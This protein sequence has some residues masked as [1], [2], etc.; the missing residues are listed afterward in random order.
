[1]KKVI[2]IL[3]ILMIPVIAGAE[4]TGWWRFDN[5]TNLGLDS[6]GCGNDGTIVGNCN[7]TTDAIAGTGALECTGGYI[8]LYSCIINNFEGDFSNGT[9]SFAMW[10]KL[11]SENPSA[12]NNGFANIGA[13]CYP[14][15]YPSTANTLS[16]KLFLSAGSPISIS[17]PIG[18]VLSAWHHFAVTVDA[19]DTSAGYKVYFDGVLIAE[20]PMDGTFGNFLPPQRPILGAGYDSSSNTWSYLLGKIDE[21]KIYNSILSQQQIQLMIYNPDLNSDK[22]VDM[23]DLRMM[24]AGWLS[25]CAS[26]DW[27]QG[28][29]INRDTYVNFDD[30]AILANEWMQ[31]LP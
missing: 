2:A 1:M 19:T 6:S 23:S 8:Q 21:V 11:A 30:F 27:C 9:A 17:L 15:Y 10:I 13:W 5:M 3:M 7:F 20:I 25:Q 29:D 12:S 26:P 16:L 4:L 24:S 22:K 31:S 28:M 18:T 14:S